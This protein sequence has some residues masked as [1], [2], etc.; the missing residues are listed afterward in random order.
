M[1]ADGQDFPHD[2][3]G[4]LRGTSARFG[5][6]AR[7]RRRDPVRCQAARSHGWSLADAAQPTRFHSRP[8]TSRR[9]ISILA[10]K[11]MLV[12][13]SRT[14]EGTM[15]L[16]LTGRFSEASR[17]ASS[18]F[19]GES[20]TETEPHI[21][22]GSQLRRSSGSARAK[23]RRARGCFGRKRVVMSRFEETQVVIANRETRGSVAGLVVVPQ[24]GRRAGPEVAARL[25]GPGPTLR[26]RRGAAWGQRCGTA[27]G[28]T[29]R[30]PCWIGGPVRR[31]PARSNPPQGATSPGSAPRQP[32][33]LPW[34]CSRFWVHRFPGTS[35]WDDGR[36]PDGS[37]PVRWFA[38]ELGGYPCFTGGVTLR[39]LTL[40]LLTLALSSSAAP[41]ESRLDKRAARVTERAAK[42]HQEAM[43]RSAS[44][45]ESPFRAGSGRKAAL[46]V[47][48][49]RMKDERVI[50]V[51][52][53]ARHL[54]DGEAEPVRR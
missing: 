20:G 4:S 32:G 41:Q 31:S 5:S 46:L 48:G 39:L 44:A 52:Q 19:R 35:S 25:R 12:G 27:S 38:H 16:G 11:G 6:Q 29:M 37:Q 45:V 15:M 22:P 17:T 47:Q 1:G 7:C 36:G 14:G 51:R 42:G 50:G 26:P 43:R 49:F 2:S 23:E 24:G 18:N 21:Y 34:P 54:S 53:V 3:I 33:P 9:T 8:Q 30:T 28:G 10:T 40:V 13:R